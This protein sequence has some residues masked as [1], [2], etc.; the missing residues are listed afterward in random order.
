[1]IISEAQYKRRKRTKERNTKEDKS[2][3]P[4][5]DSLLFLL[6]HSQQKIYISFHAF[7]DARLAYRIF[8]YV[9]RVMFVDSIAK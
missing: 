7:T 4:F 2:H 9:V 3:N 1:M 6:L 8:D 5:Y